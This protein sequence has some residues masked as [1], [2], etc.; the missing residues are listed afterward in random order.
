MRIY[1]TKKAAIKAGVD[2]D[3]LEIQ[4]LAKDHNFVNMA[5]RNTIMGIVKGT[6]E[7]GIEIFLTDKD[8]RNNFRND[9]A[10]SYP[11]KGNRGKQPKPVHYDYIRNTLLNMYNANEVTGYEA[12]DELGLWQTDP[13]VQRCINTIIASI[14]KDLLMIP[15]MHYNIN[16]KETI[17]A[18]DPGYLEVVR[19]GSKAKLKGYGFK[20]FC[21]QMLL[22]DDVDNIVGIKRYG[23]VRVYKVL[24]KSKTPKQ[25]WEEVVKVYK[26]KATMD[27]LDENAN[28]LWIMRTDA[29]TYKDYLEKQDG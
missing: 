7:S 16:T 21:A 27:R 1:P 17:E 23:P 2:K 3:T 10:I 19:T 5:L 14:D 12:D 26:A 25:M 9:T 28:L 13:K 20:W 29:K 15:G 22:G 18:S 8:V 4:Q 6:G 24:E 11:Y